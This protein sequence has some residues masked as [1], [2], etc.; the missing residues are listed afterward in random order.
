VA[1]TSIPATPGIACRDRR[2]DERRTVNISG[3]GPGPPPASGR[4]AY[5]S[6]AA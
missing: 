2:H 1:N 4:S 6:C 3:D 5:M